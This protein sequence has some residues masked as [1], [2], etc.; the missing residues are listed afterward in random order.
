MDSKAVRYLLILMLSVLITATLTGCGG[1]ETTD[2]ES[3]A[4]EMAA[5]AEEAVEGA[6]EETGEAVATELS[7]AALVMLAK[8]DALD[9]AKDMIVAK[10][11][12][13][14]LAMEGNAEYAAH[15]GE[16]ELHFCSEECKTKFNESP[17]ESL[18]AMELPELDPSKLLE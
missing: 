13:C 6:M 7:E 2:V 1:G 17:V 16:Y 12:G 5:E 3:T 9:G 8:A 11:A 10:C 18:V 4:G 14:A 15:L